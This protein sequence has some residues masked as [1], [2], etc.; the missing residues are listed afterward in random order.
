MSRLQKKALELERALVSNAKIYAHKGG[1]VGRVVGRGA[2]ERKMLPRPPCHHTLNHFFVTLS[3]KYEKGDVLTSDIRNV[4][5]TS[6]TSATDSE[7]F[8]SFANEFL[9]KTQALHEYFD[10]DQDGGLNFSELLR[11]QLHTSESDMCGNMYVMVC[12]MLG[13]NLNQ[14]VNIKALTQLKVH[15]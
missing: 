7:V 11:P 2:V 8:L 15:I 1:V 10:K 12:K 5:F 6:D 9:D 3:D 14:G 4:L 13:C